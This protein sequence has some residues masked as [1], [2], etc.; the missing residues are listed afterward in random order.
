MQSYFNT[1][2]CANKGC[3]NFN[4]L[5]AFI[6]FKPY[7]KRAETMPDASGK[8]IWH[9][10]E[11]YLARS[12]T[13]SGTQSRPSPADRPEQHVSRRGSATTAIF[14]P[15]A[16]YLLPFFTTCLLPFHHLFIVFS[17]PIYHLFATYLLPFRYLFVVFSPPV[18]CLFIT[19]LSPFRY[20][21][22]TT[23]RQCFVKFSSKKFAHSALSSYLCIRKL[24]Y[25]MQISRTC[26]SV[27]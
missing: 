9:V 22:V 24:I 10:A 2:F 1:T 25:D 4:K 23:C 26:S 15:F 13:I 27:G 19:Y 18:Y 11:P 20:L 14:S 16:T 12:Q 8:H 7:L 3:Y 5:L 6:P 17:L 21:F